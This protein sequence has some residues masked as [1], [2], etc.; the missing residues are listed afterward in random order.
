MEHGMVERP[1]KSQTTGTIEEAVTAYLEE[2]QA[3]VG[4]GSK[5]PQTH[6]ASKQILWE[7]QS[8]CERKGKKSLSKINRL[9]LLNYAG[10]A[11][12]QSPR[13]PDAQ[14]TRNSSV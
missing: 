1:K 5:R 8:W 2:L 13:N 12:E 10:W 3:R 6:S 11:Y 14:R 7:F 4:N 9:D